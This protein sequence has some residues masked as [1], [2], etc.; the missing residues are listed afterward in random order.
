MHGRLGLDGSKSKGKQC[1]LAFFGGEAPMKPMSDLP[2]HSAFEASVDGHTLRVVVSGADRLA[3]LLELISEARESLRLFFYIF[4]DSEVSHIIREA[5][6]D[7]RNRGVAVTLLVDGFGTGDKPDSVYEGFIE[8]G[9]TFAR[10]HSAWGRRYLLRNHQ[11]I[12]VADGKRALIGGTNIDDEYFGDAPDGSTWHDLYL[13]IEGEAAARL[14]AYFDELKLWMTGEGKSLRA[15]VRILAGHSDKTGKLRFLMGGP[16]RRLSPLT[17]SI[18]L[19]LHKTRRLDM[20]QAYFSPNWGMLRRF[21]RIVERNKG[22][23]RLITAARSDNEVTI[24]A[25]RHCYRRLLARGA[26][27]FEY[28]PQKLHMKLIV[29][30]NIVYLG[31]ANF[32]MR[33]LYINAEIML[34]I[35][36]KGFANQV[37]AFVEAHIPYSEAITPEVHRA[38]SGLFERARRLLCYFIVSSVD[39][40]VTRGLTLRRR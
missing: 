37:R 40:S 28:A 38:R 39:F 36:D 23:A 18:K 31:S 27:V 2:G 4:G 16:F 29:A 33:S 20:I 10:F 8:A 9:I 26:L 30:D 25:A 13:I 11:K 1:G 22:Q 32:D 15:L 17:R 6:I 24:A 35:A 3:A 14:S 21:G 34:R 19:D 5:L 7:A 12:L